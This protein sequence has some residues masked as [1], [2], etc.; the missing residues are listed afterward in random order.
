MSAADTSME[1]GALIAR[2][3]EA[4]AALRE[5]RTLGG[6]H[7]AQRWPGVAAMHGALADA[8][9]SPERLAS[10]EERARLVDDLETTMIGLYGGAGSFAD[11]GITGPGADRFEQLKDDVRRIVGR[12]R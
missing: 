2:L 3:R 7:L 5:L 8:L 6:D 4:D 11:F 10:A 9:S 12:L 1:Q